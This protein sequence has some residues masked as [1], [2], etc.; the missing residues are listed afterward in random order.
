MNTLKIDKILTHSVLGSIIF[1]LVI[2]LV[3]FVSLK[4]GGFFG[5]LL[6]LLVNDFSALVSKTLINLGVNDGTIDLLT[7]AVIKGI[8][9][10]LSFLPHLLVMFFFMT[11]LEESGYTARVSFIFDKLFSRF[12]LSGK[13]I[14]PF[15]LSCG[16]TVSGIEAS[17]VIQNGTERENTI[18]LSPFLPCGA[19]M[20]IFGWFSH[21]FF[22]GSVI[23]SVAMYLL[24]IVVLL[25]VA[26]IL[27]IFSKGQNYGGFV[28]ELPVLRIPRLYDVFIN[29]I[30]KSKEFL[31]KS[32]TTIF[33]ISIVVWML[34]N[35]GLN[36]YTFGESQKSF[37][38]Y[39]GEGLKYIFMPLGFGTWQASVSVFSGLLAKEGVVETLQILSLNPET[40]FDS[41][42]SVY[43][44]LAFNLL[45][46]PCIASISTAKRE[47]KSNVKLL[48]MIAIELVTAYLVALV[49]NL[50]GIIINLQLGLILSIIIGIII[51]AIFLVCVKNIIKGKSTCACTSCN[52][53]NCGTK[54]HVRFNER[55]G[56]C[57]RGCV[58]SRGVGRGKTKV[59]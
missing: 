16:C 52:R 45:C 23:L 21:L 38:Y 14:I 56:K 22:N 39:I 46:P 57:S 28:L 33:A 17:K 42:A 27:K 37:L 7:N 25:V 35:F 6:V 47:L 1:F 32:G 9:T 34:S 26:K 8:G 20:A 48:K 40:V 10:V 58:L 49:I 30:E 54:N 55:V 11:A 50:T 19:K 24:S 41:T 43:A 15:I 12:N 29:L 13:S 36:G 51:L 5:D 2:F 3:Y 44:F 4:V 53:N 59:S 31:L 18:M